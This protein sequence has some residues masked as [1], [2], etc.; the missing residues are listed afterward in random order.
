MFEKILI[1]SGSRCTEQFLSIQDIVDMMFYYDEVHV[2]VSQFELG[3]LLRYFGEDVLYELI[4]SKR[5]FVHPCDQ[6]IGVLSKKDEPKICSAEMFRRNFDS[7]EQLLYKYHRAYIKNSEKN[8]LFASKF[9]K[10][11]DEYRYPNFVQ[12]SICKDI[13]NDTFLSEVIRTFIKQHYPSYQNVN[14]LKLHAEPIPSQ[15]NGAYRIDGNIRMD[16]LNTIHHQLGYPGSFS[17]SSIMMAIGETA[18]DCYFSSVLMSD[19]ITKNK[20]AEVYKLKMNTCISS[21]EKNI[22]KIE[23]FHE[24]VA[25]EF[26]SPGKAFETGQITTRELLKLLECKE[27][28]KFKEWLKS[29]PNN[30]P[31]SGEF[32]NEI[33]KQNSDKLFVKCIRVLFQLFLGLIDFKAGLIST[34][35]D[36]FVCDKLINGWTPK[37]FVEKVLRND[38]LN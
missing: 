24:T 27:S 21:A 11:L 18:Q 3:Q 33:R 5:F 28:V 20:W 16:E 2:V 23:H 31:I 9:S 26:V 29:I 36:G 19:L 38:K 17:Y 22:S 1:K 35:V 15:L 37:V 7:I 10:I 13:E 12:E 8:L 4:T 6:H 14:E 32:Y 34:T 25:F 30:T